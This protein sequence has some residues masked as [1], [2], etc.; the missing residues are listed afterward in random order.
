MKVL[1]SELPG[2][3]I[4]EPSLLRDGRGYFFE[5][6]RADKYREHGIGDTFVQQNQSRSQRGTIRGL[7]LQG[8]PNPQAKLVRVLAGE[9]YDVA[10]DV[11]RGSPTFGRW[12]AV[13]LS[14]ENF[15]QWYVPCGFA[16]GFA[17]TSDVA[18]VEYKCSAFYDPVSEMGIAWNDP[19]L[20][21]RWPVNQPLLSD[22]D[23]QHP[24]LAD[25]ADRLPSFE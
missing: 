6:Y 11:R 17:V 9:I 2:V 24:R 19:A 12:A 22:R 10:V 8:S 21:I 20:A 25:I 15:R 4:V 3:L 5:A 14:A 7:H 16:H 23:R 13:T 1:H 18:E